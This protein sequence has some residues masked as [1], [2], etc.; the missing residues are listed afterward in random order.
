MK[1]TL[2]FPLFGAVGILSSSA[3]ATA[4]KFVETDADGTK[5]IR[6]PFVHVDVHHRAD[7]QKD[8]RVKAPFTKVHN[9]AGAHN[10]QIS[11]PFTKVNNSQNGGKDVS[12]PFTKVEKPTESRKAQVNAPFTKVHSNLSDSN[13]APA[14]NT[15]GQTPAGNTK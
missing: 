6:A 15:K 12:A 10:A 5:H 7:G 3:P 4:L 8:V 11:A 1:L 9:P 2:I 13:M 14:P